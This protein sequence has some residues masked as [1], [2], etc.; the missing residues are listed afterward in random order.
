MSTK[1]ATGVTSSSTS[2][3]PSLQKQ[4]NETIQSHGGEL[5][6]SPQKLEVLFQGKTYGRKPNC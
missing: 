5:S 6:T 2:A 4:S 3:M 1:F